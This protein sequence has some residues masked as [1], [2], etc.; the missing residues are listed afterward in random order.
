MLGVTRRGRV[1]RRCDRAH[2]PRGLAR[3]R[4]HLSHRRLPADGRGPTTWWSRRMVSFADGDV[5]P[6]EA[7][8]LRDLGM[9]AL[10][11]LPLVRGKA[12][13]HRAVRC[14]SGASAT[15]T[16]PSPS[17]SP[18]RRR[19]GSRSPDT[20]DPAPE[21]STGC[22]MRLC[23]GPQAARGRRTVARL[24]E[25]RATDPGDVEDRPRHL[26]RLP[27]R[28]STAS[29]ST[30]AYRSPARMQARRARRRHRKPRAGSAFSRAMRSASRASSARSRRSTVASLSPPHPALP[31]ASEV[32]F[33]VR[34][35]V[36]SRSVRSR[37]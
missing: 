21:P 7:F 18:R 34:S 17:S 16:S 36:Y 14:D 28:E 33:G 26:E 12:W 25:R 10:L 6:S 8:I 9:N 4:G 37:R 22:P 15:R 32:L 3:R 1:H 35:G 11:M 13:A 5:D 2:A 29:S 23:A 31:P 30:S 19:G 24:Q 27:T 20:A